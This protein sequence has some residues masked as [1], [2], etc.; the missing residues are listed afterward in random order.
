MLTSLS[1]QKV[2]H[3]R[4]QH[5][6]IP[7]LSSYA[8]T[9]TLKRTALSPFISEKNLAY[10]YIST[11]VLNRITMLTTFLQKNIFTK[12]TGPHK[13]LVLTQTQ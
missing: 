2:F 8:H 12:I 7:Y 13:N 6:A 5:K 1:A 11:L 3:N 9:T 4:R 10:L